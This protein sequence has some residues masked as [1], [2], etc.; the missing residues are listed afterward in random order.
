MSIERLRRLASC[1]HELGE[2]GAWFEDAV[3]EYLEHAADG[4]TLDDALGLATPDGGRPW[5]R[6][7][8]LGRRAEAIRKLAEVCAPEP[9]RSMAAMIC[10]LLR[11]YAGGRWRTD[12]MRPIENA[13]ERRKAMRAALKATG[14]AVPSRRTVERILGK[15]QVRSARDA[16]T[17]GSLSGSPDAGTEPVRCSSSKGCRHDARAQPDDGGECAGL[18]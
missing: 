11:R 10:A 6:R 14:G 17:P 16:S 7:E 12:Q 2:D 9:G 5:W 8:E 13:S 15:A 4:L 1:A 18:R 3:R